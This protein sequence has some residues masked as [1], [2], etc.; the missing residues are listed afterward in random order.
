MEKR[1]DI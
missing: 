1:I